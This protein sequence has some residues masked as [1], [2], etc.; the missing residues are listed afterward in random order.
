MRNSQA[1]YFASM[2][3]DFSMKL[4]GEWFINMEWGAMLFFFS[5]SAIS[6]D[7]FNTVFIPLELH[8]LRWKRNQKAANLK[9]EA[10]H[11]SAGFWGVEICLT[12]LIPD[13]HPS[14]VLSSKQLRSGK[15]KKGKTDPLKGLGAH[16]GSY[17]SW[18]NTLM[19]II[20]VACPGQSCLVWRWQQHLSSLH[21]KHTWS[22]CCR[23]RHR[24]QSSLLPQSSSKSETDITFSQSLCDAYRQESWK[25]GRC[26]W[27]DQEL[28]S[29]A[30]ISSLSI[31]FFLF[32][33]LHHL[34][35][36][37]SGAQWFNVPSLMAI[38][39]FRFQKLYYNSTTVLMKWAG[40]KKKSK[41][42]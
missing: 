37:F 35:S 42:Y 34:T 9:Q 38:R 7:L 11:R 2:L 12:L 20:L 16:I 26:I 1:F 17:V 22:F 24:K 18:I 30:V 41:G 32:L 39:P 27:Q 23:G 10:L 29:F 21:S 5:V 25:K 40:K 19:T 33:L 8:N 36:L 14:S 4:W 6:L 31:S 15:L 3:A 28:V 13:S